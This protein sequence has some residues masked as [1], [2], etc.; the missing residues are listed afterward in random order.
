MTRNNEKRYVQR[1]RPDYPL[2]GQLP[3][4]NVII[5]DLSTVGA[6]V[7]HQFPL[8]AG[9]RVRLEFSCE[10]ER[11]SLFCDV[12]RCK[13]QKSNGNGSVV[14]SSGLRF[15]EISEETAAALRRVIAGFVGREIAN[16][17][18]MRIRETAAAATAE[19]AFAT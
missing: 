8:A 17:K 5:V 12:T 13:L 4:G 16:K 6:R 9:R 3:T 14:Y 7:D 15:S 2:I 1:I 19:P 10:G 11:V 18:A